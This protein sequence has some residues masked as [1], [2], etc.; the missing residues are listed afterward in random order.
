MEKKGFLIY[1]D[2]L[3]MLEDLSDEELGLTML[4]LYD[5]AQEVAE[6][7][8]PLPVFLD[9]CDD[10]TPRARTALGF[11]GSAVDRDTRKWCRIRDAR[12]AKKR[13]AERAKLERQ[14]LSAPLDYE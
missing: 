3:P 5:F 10:L 6:L 13:E 4:R 7:G 8:T 14:A 2:W 12:E 9:R 1:F 11:M